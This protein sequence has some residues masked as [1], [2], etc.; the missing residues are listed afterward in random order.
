MKRRLFALGLTLA[1]A[2][3]VGQA[4]SEDEKTSTIRGSIV[5]PT[6]PPAE[7]IIAA[8][9][10]I[11]ACVVKGAVKEQ[12]W[13]VDAKTKG[14]KNIFVWI[15]PAGAKRGAPFPKESIHP[16]AAKVPA[17]PA[18]IDQPCCAFEP[19]VVAVRVGQ[20]FIVKNSAPIAHNAKWASSGNGEVNPLIPA[21]SQYKL[22]APIALEKN[23]INLSCNIH[24]WMNAFV[25]VYDHPYYAI[26]DKD[27]KFEIPMALP[28]KYIMYVWHET[29][30]IAGKAGA[31]GT[32]I[33]LKAGV[34]DLKET[35]WK[36][37]E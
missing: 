34:N 14:I 17:V 23:A 16:K 6:A 36:F 18:F 32:P 11:P 30:W 28:G 33:E 3:F 7:K 13:E 35:E 2:T 15:E 31:K 22:E 4:R 24:G 5:Y 26:T 37:G 25:R 27:G 12:V 20:E 1:F 8:A 21:N 9:S 29:G 19:R 10:G